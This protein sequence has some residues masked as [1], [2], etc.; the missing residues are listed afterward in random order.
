M[1]AVDF[2]IDDHVVGVGLDQLVQRGVQG[3]GKID[4][5]VKAS[6]RCPVSIRLSEDGF[7]FARPASSS[8]DQP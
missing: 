4:Q 1:R 2:R 6:R 8:S 3:P 7:S 5:L